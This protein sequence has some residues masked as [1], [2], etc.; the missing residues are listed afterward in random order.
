MVDLAATLP[1]G[2]TEA[3]QP[4]ATN[5]G[6]IPKMKN[7]AWRQQS[8]KSPLDSLY[9]DDYDTGADDYDKWGVPGLVMLPYPVYTT[10]RVMGPHGLEDVYPPD[11]VWA[12]QDYDGLYNIAEVTMLII[13]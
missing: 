10:Q 12:Y 13:L 6:K 5:M 7:K 1:Q 4:E 9:S 3:L 2:E 8:A 11:D